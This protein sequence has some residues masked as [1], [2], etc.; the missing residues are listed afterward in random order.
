MSEDVKRQM[1]LSNARDLALHATPT[2]R[3]FATVC[4]VCLNQTAFIFVSMIDEVPSGLAAICFR[5][6]RDKLQTTSM[7]C[8]AYHYYYVRP[9]ALPQE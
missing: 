2:F 4:T 9:S 8:I 1:T 7:I 3:I 6:L 5:H